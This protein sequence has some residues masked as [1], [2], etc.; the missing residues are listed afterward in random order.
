M[1]HLFAEC[2]GRPL[3]AEPAYSD[4]RVKLQMRSAIDVYI[5]TTAR[6]LSIVNQN[7]PRP[8]KELPAHRQDQIVSHLCAL[9]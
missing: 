4:A 8:I 1:I 5:Y 6:A 7:P 2:A 3:I 9:R